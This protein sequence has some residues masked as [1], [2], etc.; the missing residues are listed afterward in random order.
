MVLMG[1][2]FGGYMSAQYA[3]KVRQV[4]RASFSPFIGITG[5]L[6]PRFVRFLGGKRCQ[7]IN[8]L[9]S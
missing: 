9:S 8:T 5:S 6:R 4:A 7:R 2:S 3:L 1:H